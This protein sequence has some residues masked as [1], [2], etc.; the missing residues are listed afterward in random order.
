MQSNVMMNVMK[1]ALVYLLAAIFIGL[2]IL[3]SSILRVFKRQSLFVIKQRADAKDGNAAKL[4]PLFLVRNQTAWLA[5]SLI[6]VS[7]LSLVLILAWKFWAPIAVIITAAGLLAGSYLINYVISY[8]QIETL[9]AKISPYTHEGLLFLKPGVIVLRSWFVRRPVDVSLPF[10]NKEELTTLI[11]DSQSAQSHLTGDERSIA[12][13]ALTFSD[14]TILETMI[15]RRVVK[16]VDVNATIDLK[17]LKR[18]HDSGFSRFPV[19]D[20]TLDTVV[21]TLYLKSLVGAAK[22]DT[23]K[24]KDVYDKQVYFVNESQTLNHA[25]NAF[26]H[27]KHHLFVVVNEFQEMTGVITIE[28]ILEQLIGRKIVDE[29]DQYD[30]LREVAAL[31]AKKDKKSQPDPVEA[32]AIAAAPSEPKA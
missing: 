2:L 4:Y 9:A 21:G 14:K 7:E 13:H 25:L 15:P 32:E 3:C 11:R 19:Y 16:G 5:R 17:L 27:T 20:G 6:V 24:V 18:L 12:V 31:A 30:D 29:F 22:S 23:R 10:S 1:T 28:D 26:L 8:V